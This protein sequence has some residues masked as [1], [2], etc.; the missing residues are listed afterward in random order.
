MCLREGTSS[1]RSALLSG[2]NREVVSKLVFRMLS[3]REES[4]DVGEVAILFAIG[5]YDFGTNVL[6]RCR[7]DVHFSVRDL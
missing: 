6:R 3:M 1:D 2:A 5:E 4:D 7:V